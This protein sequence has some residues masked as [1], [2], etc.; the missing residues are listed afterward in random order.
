MLKCPR[1]G[2]TARWLGVPLLRGPLCRRLGEQALAMLAFPSD[3][4]FGFAFTERP[5]KGSA[6]TTGPRR[7]GWDVYNPYKELQVPTTLL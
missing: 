1:R 5:V 6:A 2:V 7:P 3:P 4:K